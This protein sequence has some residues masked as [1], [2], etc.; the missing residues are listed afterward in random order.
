MTRA[1]YFQTEA[2]GH[3]HAFTPG[4]RLTLC[5]ITHHERFWRPGLVRCPVCVRKLAERKEAATVPPR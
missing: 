3:E 4:S 5:G 2:H 1:A